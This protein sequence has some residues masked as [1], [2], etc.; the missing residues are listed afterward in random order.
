MEAV[1]A[2]ALLNSRAVLASI[3]SDVPLNTR[4]I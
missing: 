3:L 4:A 1:A 2:V